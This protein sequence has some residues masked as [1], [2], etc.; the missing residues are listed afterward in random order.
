MAWDD[1]DVA[2]LKVKQSKTGAK[3]MPSTNLKISTADLRLGNVP[4][5]YGNQGY[6]IKNHSGKMLNND[7]MPKIFSTARNS[8]NFEWNGS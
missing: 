7:P 3:P 1:F 6:L 8:L 2:T 4:E 5:R